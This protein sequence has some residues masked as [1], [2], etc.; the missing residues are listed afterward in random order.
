MSPKSKRNIRRM[1]ALIR[2]EEQLQFNGYPTFINGEAVM[3]KLIDKRKEELKKEIVT[4]KE[5][6]VK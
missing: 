2:S 1:N 6:I 3:I 5:R 4:L